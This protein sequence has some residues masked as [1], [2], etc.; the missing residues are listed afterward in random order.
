MANYETILLGRV[1]DNNAYNKLLEF[2]MKEHD[3]VTEAGKQGFRFIKQYYEKYNKTPSTVILL[4]NIENFPYVA[5]NDDYGYLAKMT[6]N[7][8]AGVT[9]AEYSAKMQE[10]FDKYSQS[11]MLRFIEITMNDLELLKTRT[12]ISNKIG[13]SVKDTQDYQAEYLKRKEGKVSQVWQSKFN[14]INQEIGGYT[15]GDMYTWFGKSGRGK[16]TITTAECVHAARHG[17]RV[18]IWTMEMARFEVISRIYSMLSADIG[19]VKITIDDLEYMGGF[20]NSEL[21]AGKLNDNNEQSFF[22]MLSEINDE[23]KGEIIIRSVDD[24]DFYDRNLNRL[25]SDIQNSRADIVMID[26]FYYLDYERNTS[27]TSGGDAANTSIKL[28]RLAGQMQVVI[29][30]ITQ[31]DEVNEKFSEEDRELVVPARKDVKKTK[32]VLEDATCLFAIDT[33]YKQ[34]RGIISIQKGRN[35][36]E[37]TEIDIT[38]LPNY[39]IIK[40][41]S[42]DVSDFNF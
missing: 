38:Y 3:F 12:S 9:M 32:Q 8:A 29:H 16:S 39:G 42:L 41:I 40:E 13:T 27:K 5:S 23:I 37:G 20:S 19:K 35:G 14:T 33:N 11:D 17:A 22:S 21:R 7:W 2:D 34:K 10:N 25:K 1:T 31:A 24:E 4:D 15:C 28:K 18:L 30:V 6:K 36:G 26:P